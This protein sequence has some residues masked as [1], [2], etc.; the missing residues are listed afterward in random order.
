MHLSTQNKTGEKNGMDEVGR[1]GGDNGEGP[2]IGKTEMAQIFRDGRKTL[3]ARLNRKDSVAVTSSE[4]DEAAA[5]EA[6]YE[7]VDEDLATLT[8]EASKSPAA[9]MAK[10]VQEIPKEIVQGY[11]VPKPRPKPLEILVMAAASMDISDLNIEPTSAPPPTQVLKSKPSVIA[12]NLGVVE[13]AETLIEQQTLA[14]MS[15]ASAKG[16]FADAV[17]NGT[18]EG[19]PLIK[20]QM[21]SFDDINWWPAQA[22]SDPEQSVRRDGAPQE[23]TTNENSLLPSAQAQPVSAASLQRPIV[24]AQ[25]SALPFDNGD[26]LV[27]NRSGKGSLPENLRLEQSGFQEIGQLESN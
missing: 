8:E 12:D 7:G 18:A 6:A 5:L 10:P 11:P 2:A 17:R 20:P 13:A 24:I 25:N 14:Q 4:A 21:A 27:V 16:S 22:V 15:N 3:G 26:V 9:P 1:Q 23:F 19:V